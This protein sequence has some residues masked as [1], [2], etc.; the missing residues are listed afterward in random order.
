[1]GMLTLSGR[2]EAILPNRQYS[3]NVCK[4]FWLG[5]HEVF[6]T[7]DVPSIDNCNPLTTLTTVAMRAF[8]FYTWSSVQRNLEPVGGVAS[9][10]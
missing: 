2:W 1:M 5:S 10:F 6:G 7:W 9:L 3:G 8:W 4:L